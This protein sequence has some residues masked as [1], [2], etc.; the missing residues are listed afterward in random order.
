MN[1]KFNGIKMNDAADNPELVNDDA[2]KDGCATSSAAV[3]AASSPRTCNP[4]IDLTF[5]AERWSPCGEQ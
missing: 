4:E 2:K 1:N 3:P 5:E